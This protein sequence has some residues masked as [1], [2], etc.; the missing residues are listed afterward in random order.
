MTETHK[1]PGCRDRVRVWRV[2]DVRPIYYGVVVT[3]EC[4]EGHE[5]IE[6]RRSA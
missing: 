5:V 1:C 2:T 6:H 4:S 3:R